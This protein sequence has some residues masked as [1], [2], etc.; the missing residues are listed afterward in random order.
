MC[1]SPC[2]ETFISFPVVDSNIPWTWLTSVQHVQWVMEIIGQGFTLPP[3]ED[4]VKIIQNACAIYTQWL[5]DSSARPYIIQAKEGKSIEQIF[6]QR[7]FHH[8]SLIFYINEKTTIYHQELCKQVL[9]VMSMAER[10]LSNRFSEETWIILLKVLLGI[11]DY[12]LREP[13]GKP[14][15]DIISNS[16]MADKLCEN[17]IRVLIESWLRSQTKRTDMWESLKKYFKNWT[18]RIGVIEQWNATMFGL[19]QKVINILYG[20]NYGKNNV[21]IVIN[22]SIISLDLSSDFVIYSW[23]QMLCIYYYYFFFI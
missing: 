12:L 20:P 18:H 10:T 21:N 5:L 15:S 4:N 23:A 2:T 16:V 17:V 6:W 8:F 14:N 7:I 13:L 9:S 22:G 3:T 19:T 11:S 1:E